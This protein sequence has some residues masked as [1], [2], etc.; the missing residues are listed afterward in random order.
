M[1]A[2]F[3]LSLAIA[4]LTSCSKKLVSTNNSVK[5]STY[6]REIIKHDTVH[7]KGD[8]VSIIQRIECDSITNKPKPIMIKEHVGRARASVQVKANGELK[9]V[10]SCDSLQLIVN[11]LDKEVF[12]LRH[13]QKDTTIVNHP[14]KFKIWI[15]YTAY[16]LAIIFI[17]YIVFNVVKRIYLP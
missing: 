17:L 6:V 5:D 9:V 7:V 1:R 8:T 15:D 11:T 4:S 16:F 12:H 10:A 2:L 13:E 3:I 14:S